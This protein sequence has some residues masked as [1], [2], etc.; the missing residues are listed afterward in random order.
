MMPIATDN[1]TQSPSQQ[2]SEKIYQPPRPTNKKSQPTK[3]WPLRQETLG[4]RLIIQRVST[5]L[6]RRMMRTV[7][8]SHWSLEGVGHLRRGRTNHWASRGRTPTLTRLFKPPP[9]VHELNYDLRTVLNTC[10][11]YCVYMCSI[12]SP[13]HFYGHKLYM[14]LCMYLQGVLLSGCSWLGI[15]TIK[16]GLCVQSSN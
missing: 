8:T 11:V 7:S 4:Q 1:H 3:T 15:I 16:P 12:V 6:L 10:F 9:P 2:S 13:T 5:I 14:Y